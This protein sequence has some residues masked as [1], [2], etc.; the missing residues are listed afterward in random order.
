MRSWERRMMCAAESRPKTGLKY[1]EIIG[2]IPAKR[3][4]VA[5]PPR[6]LSAHDLVADR[7]SYDGKRFVVRPYEKLTALLELQSEIRYRN[8]AH[9]QK[10]I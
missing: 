9:E 8:Q 2:I 7:Y 3:V 10:S 1:W 5:W 4:G 6:S